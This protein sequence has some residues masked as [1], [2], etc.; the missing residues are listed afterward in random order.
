MEAYLEME[1]FVAAF[2]RGD[3]EAF[4]RFYNDHWEKAFAYAYSFT[5]KKVEAE[6]IAINAFC[7]LWEDRQMVKSGKNIYARLLLTIRNDCL[8]YWRSTSR[9]PLHLERYKD[10]LLSEKEPEFSFYESILVDKS[11]EVA[12][13]NLRKAIENLPTEYGRVMRLIYLKGLKYQDVAAE[14]DLSINTVKSYRR[15]AIQK[16]KNDLRSQPVTLSLLFAIWLI[17]NRL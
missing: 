14:M 16:L 12:V 8:D 2:V 17:N 1:D 10:L 4:D 6:D 5:R 13:L 9:L 3:K 15:L 7:E 11:H